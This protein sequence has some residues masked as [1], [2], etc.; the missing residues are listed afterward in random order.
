MWLE[1]SSPPLSHRSA[2][3]DLLSTALTDCGK[4]PEAQVRLVFEV[5]SES[6][7]NWQ[8]QCCPVLRVL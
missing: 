8:S 6:A 3:L 1:N 7:K 2:L 5:C 4:E